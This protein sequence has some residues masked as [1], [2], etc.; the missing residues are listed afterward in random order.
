[1]STPQEITDISGTTNT[2]EASSESQV[3]WC[4]AKLEYT[5]NEGGKVIW[6]DVVPG[7]LYSL[8]MGSGASE[9]ALLDMA[10]QLFEP[11]Q[12]YN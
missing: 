6:F 4:S 5:E 7:I 3:L 2:F 11:A 12:A 1:M 10:A 8:H 9:E